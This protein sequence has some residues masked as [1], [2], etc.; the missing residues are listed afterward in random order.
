MIS[1]VTENSFTVDAEYDNYGEVSVME[2]KIVSENGTWKIDSF[3][4]Q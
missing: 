3:S 1:D 2:I 4:A